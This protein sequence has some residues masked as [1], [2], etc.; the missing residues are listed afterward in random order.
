MWVNPDVNM[1]QT[2]ITAQRE[3]SLVVF[4]GAGVSM[5]APSN[6][7]GYDELAGAIAAGSV[8]RQPQEPSDRFLGRAEQ[9]GVDVQGSC[10]LRL[11]P[12]GS[13]P[14]PL[15][16]SILALFASHT[17]MRVVTT[18]FDRHFETVRSQVHPAAE[19]Y[20]APALPL[21]GSFDGVVYLHGHI[22]RRA[23]LV[24]TDGDFGRA[25]LTEGWATRF[26]TEMFRA[27][28]VLF[29]GYSHED[30]VMRYLARAF[31]GPTDRFAFC[32]PEREDYWRRHDI[33]PIRFPPGVSADRFSAIPEA[34][35]SWSALARM[36]VLDHGDRIRELVAHPPPLEPELLDYLRLALDRESTLQV[37]TDEARSHEWLEWADKR[38]NRKL[39]MRL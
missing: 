35:S 17:T 12:D 37:F 36:K 29:I 27:Y 20:F 23:P 5:G 18:N 1:P 7:P 26:L 32:E 39:G 9:Q 19:T 4:A 16:R 22:D 2:L 10:R 28:A 13:E 21:G 30:P 33:T 8:T 3:G 25:Y 34:L 14:T 15:H 31:S 6:L 11:Q 24:I 38:Y